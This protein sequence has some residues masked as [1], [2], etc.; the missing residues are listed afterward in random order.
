MDHTPSS[1][2][3]LQSEYQVPRREAVDALLAID[4]LRD[5]ISPLLQISEIRTIAADELWM[6]PSFGRDSVAIHFTW[7]PDW[8]AVRQVLP[9]IEEALAPFEPRPHWGKLF[10]IPPDRL[11]SLYPKRADFAALLRRH[12]PLGKFRNK[13]L[14]RYLFGPAQ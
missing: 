7:L 13:F 12:D 3:E 4:A 6:S 5:R 1:G 2:D 14:D 9:Q 10:T 8:R 11:G